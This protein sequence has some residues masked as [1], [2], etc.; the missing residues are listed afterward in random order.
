MTDEKR[1]TFDPG[2]LTIG[3]L[4]SK[5][6]EQ[7]PEVYDVIE[8]RREIT[9]KFPDNFDKAVERGKKNFTGNFFIE[10]ELKHEKLF[11]I[12]RTYFNARRTCP[13][14]YYDQAVFIYNRKD[15][16]VELLWTIPNHNTARRIKN[17]P[18]DLPEH[19]EKLRPYVFD[20]YDKTL[21]R[22][23]NDLN[24]IKNNLII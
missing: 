12:Q 3:S 16:K 9:K 15:D 14:P 17:F 23:S 21:L 5:V 2:R 20:F 24:G 7:E 19:E 13:I 10:I 18:I 8:L 1:S 22:K 6:R 11:P 4:M